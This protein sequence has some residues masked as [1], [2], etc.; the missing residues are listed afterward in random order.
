MST[1]TARS[2]LENK[3]ELIVNTKLVLPESPSLS[4][5]SSIESAAE[6]S[7]VIVPRPLL[8]PITTRVASLLPSK[9]TA[10]RSTVKVSSISTIWSPSTLTVTVV[11]LVL[12][13]I[14]TA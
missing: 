5:T 1:V 8:S 9:R 11:E 14:V 13:R 7:F 4:E 10:D 6:S 12:A 2:L 3:S